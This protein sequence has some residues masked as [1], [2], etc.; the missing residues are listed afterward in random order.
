MD[1]EKIIYSRQSV[2]KYG[3][4]KVDIESIKKI[5]NAGIYAPSANN[6]QG[7]K[8]IYID[9]EKILKDME[10]MGGA[11]LLRVVHQVILVIYDSRLES[12]EENE[13]DLYLKGVAYKGDIQSGAAC[14]EN[15]LLM[16]TYLGVATCWM[17]WLPNPNELVEYFDIPS[18][19]T[20]IGAVALG[21]AEYEPRK[22]ER[23]YEVDD[24]LFYNQY[25]VKNNDNL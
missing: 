25:G 3:K 1:I 24:V 11:F 5:I 7:W 8:F 19:Y 13:R 6:V 4:E 20:I 22:I 21:Y 12:V 14:I 18:G 10:R 17:N 15:M 9:D 16:A 2:R 23:K